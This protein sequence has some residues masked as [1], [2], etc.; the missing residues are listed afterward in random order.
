[1]SS[2]VKI[3]GVTCIEH[4]RAA[5]DAGANAVG[6]VFAES[7]RRIAPADAAGIVRALPAKLWKV[8]LFVD[9]DAD[10]I[11]MHVRDVGLTHVQLHGQEP[12]T[13][14][15]ELAAPV[16]KAFRLQD[17]ESIT[18]M[19]DW[20]VCVA[21]ER[22]AAVLIDAFS[23]AA[24]GGTGKRIDKHLLG[25]AVAQGWLQGIDH[26]MLAGGLTPENVVESMDFVRPWGVDV[27]SGVESSPGVKDPERILRFIAAARGA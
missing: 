17:A 11:N 12:P 21:P 13:L 27:S 15:S 16:L 23:P 5:A 1:M 26:L 7:P 25:E 9:A 3:C 6:L 8:G 14:P 10:T 18:K 4:A 20:L 24:H 22:L 2:F 19:H